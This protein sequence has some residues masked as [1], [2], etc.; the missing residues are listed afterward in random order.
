M[1]ANNAVMKTFGEPRKE[2]KLFNHV[3]LVLLLDVVN[4]EQGA[5]VAG[6]GF[7]AA[8]VF[9][10]CPPCFLPTPFPLAAARGATG[11][12]EPAVGGFVRS[13]LVRS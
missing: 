3:N 11:T 8:V 7:P 4:L 6:G 12:M 10:C 13:V 1:Q 2:E 9:V 5:S